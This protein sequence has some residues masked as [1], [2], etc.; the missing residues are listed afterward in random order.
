MTGRLELTS[1]GSKATGR[2]NEHKSYEMKTIRFPRGLIKAMTIRN[3]RERL[4]VELRDA[5]QESC[6]D[7]ENIFGEFTTL[8]TELLQELDGITPDESGRAVR[9]ERK[10]S[11]SYYFG[12]D[13]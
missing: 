8:V 11:T 1:N 7:E 2:D 5:L 13:L 6:K 3:G 10:T 9:A 12:L 4:L